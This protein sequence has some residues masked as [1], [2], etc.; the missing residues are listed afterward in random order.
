MADKFIP[1][2]AEHF[3]NVKFS[4]SYIC[5]YLLPLCDQEY[6]ELKIEDYASHILKDKPN[7]IK[8]DNFLNNIYE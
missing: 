4:E 3:F 2:F 1:V 7:F 6:E 8:D 5:G